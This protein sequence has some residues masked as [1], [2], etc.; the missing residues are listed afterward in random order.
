MSSKFEE[1]QDVLASRQA[2][3]Q[4]VLNEQLRLRAAGE[5]MPDVSLMAAHPELMPELGEELRKVRIIAGARENAF[6]P[7][8][9][10]GEQTVEHKPNRKD[11]RGLHI[12]CPHCSNFVEVITDTP[13]EEISCSTCGS[14]FS[15]VEREE[16]TRMAAPL[17]SIGRFDLVTR[18]GVGGFGTVWKARDRELDRTVAVKIPRRGQ[19]TP[20]EI[21][22]FFREARAAAQLRHPNIVPVHEVGRDG[23]SLFI[24]S[25]LVRGVTLTDWLTANSISS[26]EV[27]ELCI[28]IA[29]ALHHAHEQGVVHRDLKPSNIMIDESGRPH[30][31]DF[32]LAKREIGEITMTV[33]GQI[34]GTPG[35]MSPEQARGQSHWT[36]RRTDVYSFGVILFQLLAGELPFRGNAQMQI[37]Q[38]LTEDAPDPR[39]L[40]RHIPRDLATI[41]LKCMEREPGRR[42]STAIE[43]A[44]ELNRFLRGEPIRARPVSRPARLARWAKRKPWI[45]T[46]AALTIFLAIAGPLGFVRIETLERF[47]QTRMT[48]RGKLMARS[49][50]EIN[51]ANTTIEDLRRQLDVWEG[52][53]NPSEF[54]PPLRDKPPRQMLIANLFDRSRTALADRLHSGNFGPEPTARGYMA[55]AT[56]AEAVG[57]RSLATEYYKSARDALVALQ[58]QKPDQP[59]YAGALAEC[60]TQIA[61]LSSKDD[62]IQATKDYEAARTIYKQLAAN[63]RLT[64]IPQIDWLEAEIKSAMLANPDA[65]KAHLTRVEQIKRTLPASATSDPNALYE[66]AYYLTEKPPVLSQSTVTQI[67]APTSATPSP[68]SR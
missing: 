64:A 30:L 51:Q 36:D 13:Y 47:V 54:W 44:E 46:T 41:C 60:Y 22:Q 20:A 2:R 61:N 23:E 4:T 19:L 63:Q 33:D 14:A 3:I 68:S 21:D 35:Y 28:P 42:Y 29:D 67:P 62:R 27:A 15:L 18:L 26:R 55:L 40:N 16:S 37:H 10:D 56:M 52:R 8:E 57:N 24:V 50:S 53:G 7:A 45:A 66:L 17:K 43:L 59:Q 34:L 39:K 31:T 32:G 12:R 11:S 48:E 38:R 5:A 49:G 9:H 1:T 58:K 6:A 25:D 65:V